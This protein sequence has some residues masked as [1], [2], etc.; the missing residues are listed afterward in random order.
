MGMIQDDQIQN[1]FVR[2]TE[3]EDQ[4]FYIGFLKDDMSIIIHFD[5]Y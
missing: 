5:S 4:Y 2:Q 3:H 1:G